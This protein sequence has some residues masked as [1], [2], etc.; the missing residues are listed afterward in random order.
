MKVLWHSKGPTT[1]QEQATWTLENNSAPI[2]PAPQGV[3]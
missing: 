1:L 3:K 2:W